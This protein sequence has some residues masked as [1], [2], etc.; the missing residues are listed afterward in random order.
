MFETSRS[1]PPSYFRRRMTSDRLTNDLQHF[2]G[3][4]VRPLLQD[5]DGGRFHLKMEE[6]IQS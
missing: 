4:D 2:A 5:R 6:K 3:R 1:E